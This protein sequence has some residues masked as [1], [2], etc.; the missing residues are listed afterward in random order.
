MHFI[1]LVLALGSSTAFPTPT[2]LS[3]AGAFTIS[4]GGHLPR[5]AM[6]GTDA[7][8]TRVNGLARVATFIIVI[9]P[10]VGA[11]GFFASLC[12]SARG[13]KS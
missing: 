6:Q 8:A 4:R 1:I 9:G 3:G 7:R 13:P 12:L 5:T 10:V 2:S 11:F